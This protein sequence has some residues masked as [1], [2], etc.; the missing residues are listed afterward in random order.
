M[1]LRFLR[2][3]QLRNQRIRDGISDEIS[4][5]GLELARLADL[6]ADVLTEGKRV[7]EHLAALQTR[8]ETESESSK[9]ALRRKALLR[10]IVCC[11][12]SVLVDDFLLLEARQHCSKKADSRLFLSFELSLLRLWNILLSRI[13]SCWRISGDFKLTLPRP[14]CLLI[15]TR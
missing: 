6:P 10:V 1:F 2:Y 12:P 8:H 11:V 15:R 5:Y 7:A 3:F 13:E 4:H 14:S 9:I